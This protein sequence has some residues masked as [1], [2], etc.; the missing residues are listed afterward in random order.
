MD[1]YIVYH[2]VVLKHR[3]AATNG[4]EAKEKS[5]NHLRS[6]LG[7]LRDC[8]DLCDLSIRGTTTSTFE[9]SLK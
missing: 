8:A 3:V 2:S 1:S 6:K 5:E 9:K 7:T 4:E